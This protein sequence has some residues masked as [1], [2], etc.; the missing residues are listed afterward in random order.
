MDN[1]DTKPD[2]S[3]EQNIENKQLGELLKSYRETAN[4]DI[5]QAADKLCLTAGTLISLENEKFD[6]LPEAPYIRGYLRG[7]AKLA[8]VNSAEIIALYEESRGGS[9]K[10]NLQYNFAPS[11]SVNNIIKPII[12]PYWI[13]L[14]M[15]AI[16]FLIVA[17]ISMIPGV[18]EWTSSIWDEFSEKAVIAEQ[19]NSDKPAAEQQSTNLST[20][21]PVQ[22]ANT[23]DAPIEI[24]ANTQQAKP[25]SE[26]ASSA[27]LKPNNSMDGAIN[28][29]ATP[30]GE[31][32]NNTDTTQNTEGK[33]LDEPKKTTPAD[34]SNTEAKKPTKEATKE[35]TTTPLAA[36][37]T[38]A[39]PSTGDTAQSNDTKT[40]NTAANDDAA[41]NKEKKDTQ[42]TT[43]D[44]SKVDTTAGEV[45]VKLVF[46][47]EVW[48]RVNSNK[49]KV[50]SGLKKAGAAEEF[51]T[52]M[53]LSFKV[54][55]APG[56]DIYINGKLYN[57][58]PHIRGV[59]ARF[60]VAEKVEVNQ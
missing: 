9:A 25:S 52:K 32:P 3:S 54:G 40:E 53:P 15:I 20:T 12:P 21:S 10:A 43:V 56:V 55:N 42:T 41:K 14:G 44:L 36:N 34:T 7:Y 24:V 27:S 59:V 4:M 38:T 31:T 18:K 22:A 29:Q 5:E 49:K 30:P 23:T 26:P 2:S 28:R 16:V 13:Q 45:I 57:Q 8:N 17:I 47:D 46:K 39:T 37:S 51:K 35:A 6:L 48:M 11:A 58:T 60:K 1:T 33:T 50:F 19:G